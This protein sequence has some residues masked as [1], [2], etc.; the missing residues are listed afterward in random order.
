MKS[1]FWGLVLL[2]GLSVGASFLMR[3]P[4][5][6]DFVTSEPN[7]KA[8]VPSEKKEALVTAALKDPSAKTGTEQSTAEQSIAEQ[9]T[10]LSNQ[11][12]SIDT[13]RIDT[14]GAVVLAGRV[15][16]KGVTRV[17]VDGQTLEEVEPDHLG[18]FVAMF[19]L[20]VSTEPRVL[21]LQSELEN[22]DIIESD[23]RIIVSP[24][25]ITTSKATDTDTDEG[26]DAD[27]A[28]ESP[29]VLMETDEGVEVV[30]APKEETQ[31]DQVMLDTITYSTAG[32]VT[33]KGRGSMGRHIQIYVNNQPITG[34]Q[35]ADGGE[36][37]AQLDG[38]DAGT[39]T[40]R[41]DEVQS[42]GKVKSRIETPFK[43]EDKTEMSK[44]AESTG[45]PVVT[46]QP[47]A[48]L[49]AISREKYGEGTMYVRIFEANK[50]RIRNPDLIYPGQ[51]F[52]LPN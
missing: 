38:V 48:S 20:P 31:P 19:D 18:Q 9:N 49:W 10:A 47:G 33:L 22:G 52:S 27:S 26:T 8:S 11:T 39:H 36:W 34:T 13:I 35:T 16:A 44:L 41:I 4:H 21:T 51:I 23:N 15:A 28:E 30:Q 42:D 50:E 46:V 32:D 5:A 12:P 24:E 7:S 40:L 25:T 17:A 37:T 43:R 14:D 6:L 2:A 45:K 29:T 3:N 1:V